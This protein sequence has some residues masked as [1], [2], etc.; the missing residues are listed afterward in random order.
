MNRTVPPPSRPGDLDAWLSAFFRSEMPDPWPSFQPPAERKAPPTLPAPRK[1]PGRWPLFRSRLA[2]AASVGL[3]V[4]SGL[5]LPGRLGDPA[6]KAS[7]PVPGDATS[8][9]ADKYP[10]P[11]DFDD[12]KENSLPRKVKTSMSLEQERD[13]TGFRIEVEALPSDR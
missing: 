10:F 8:N 1:A 6:R 11:F 12:G 5:A 13:R 4:L 7:G 3:L 9:K 2:L